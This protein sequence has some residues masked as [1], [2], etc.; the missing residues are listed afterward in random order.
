MEEGLKRLDTEIKRTDSLLYQMLPKT[1]AD[2]LRKGVPSVDTCKVI[3]SLFTYP[4]VS[5]SVA[6]AL[7]ALNTGTKH[8]A[9]RGSNLTLDVNKSA[10]QPGHHYHRSPVPAPWS[11]DTHGCDHQKCCDSQASGLTS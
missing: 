6:H 2:G 5:S 10:S 1:V 9:D 8:L 3:V 4:Q 11:L 7:K